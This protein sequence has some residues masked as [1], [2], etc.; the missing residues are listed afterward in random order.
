[1][2]S[3]GFDG[4][5]YNTRTGELHLVDNKSPRATGNV[6]SATAIDPSRNLPANVDGLITRVEAAQDV[7]G[8]VRI[9][10]RL[11]QTKAALAAGKP[12]PTDVKL[13]VTSVGGRTTDVS[14]RLKAQGRASTTTAPD[15]R[16]GVSAGRSPRRADDDRA[17]N[18]DPN[19]NARACC[20][21]RIRDVDG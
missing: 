15:S 10:G 19:G 6:H 16:R 4:V 20:P 2:T 3:P 5:A 11:R 14:P 12:L 7:P 1:V 13:V 8:R 9:L 21:R 18:N 17:N